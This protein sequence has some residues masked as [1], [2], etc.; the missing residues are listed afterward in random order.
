MGDA[1][2]EPMNEVHIAPI[3]RP[4]TRRGTRKLA[5]FLARRQAWRV[6]HAVLSERLREEPEDLEVARTLRTLERTALA[7]L[8]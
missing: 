6:L 1:S 2:Q 5:L 7:T 4:G 3:V 8:G